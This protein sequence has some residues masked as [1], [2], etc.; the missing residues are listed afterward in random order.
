MTDHDHTRSHSGHVH[1]PQ[2]FSRAFAVGTALNVAFVVVE[3]AFGVAANSMALLA[4]AGHNLSDVIGLLFA[5]GAG[6][7]AKRPP[8][9]RFTYGLRSS[10]ILAALANAVLLM[11]AV[12]G[13]MWEALQRFWTPAPIAAGTV[14]IVAAIGIAINLGTALM[15]MSGRK[16]DINIRGAYLH[17]AAD[18]AVSA[19]VV[20]AGFIMLATGWTW[21]DPLVSLVIAAIIVWGTWSLLRDSLSMALHAVPT[22][23]DTAA[24]RR[25]LEGLDGVDRIH[26]LH[27]WPMSTTETALTCHLVMPTG[28]PGDAF[29]ARAAA[30]LARQFGIA[31]P[32]L[33]IETGDSGSSCALEPDH[34]V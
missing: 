14:I 6:T 32:T 20:V 2:D 26:D 33:Q 5:W 27:I 12:G 10:S 28:H 25:L 8:T 30:E 29:L 15:F 23:I 18:A 3:I 24:V 22:N 34:V 19:G 17:M 11:I 7:L 4:D 1:A 16:E 9:Q 31:H 21:I 13:I